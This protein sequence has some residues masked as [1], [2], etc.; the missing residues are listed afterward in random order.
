[1]LS[2][3]LKHRANQYLPPDTKVN[4]LVDDLA[5]GILLANVLEKISEEKVGRI[6]KNPKMDIQKLENLNQCLDFIKAH[7]IPL[8]NVGSSDILKGN[9]KIILGLM[10]TIILRF[11]VSGADGKAGLLLWLQ[12]STKG[13]AGVD[14]KDFTHSWQDGLAFNALIHRYRPDLVNF[15]SLNTADSLGNCENAFGV[16]ETSLNIARLLD[17]EDVVAMPDEKSQVAYL[18]QFFKLFA[19]QAKLES[20]LKA[21]KNAVEVTRRHDDWI[22]QYNSGSETVTTF[23][24]QSKSLYSL[25][26]ACTT[27]E[28]VK[29]KLD[30]FSMYMKSV[31]PDMASK[32]AESDGI[33]TSLNSSKRNNKRPEFAPAISQ[34]SLNSEWDELEALEQ[35]YERTLLDKYLA[36]MVADHLV[37]Q[38]NAKSATVRTW[39]DEKA[40]LFSANNLG[41][42]VPDI[43]ANLEV[44][45]TFENRFT[46]Y[47]GVVQELEAIVGK[48]AS[49]EGH[50]AASGMKQSMEGL[51]AQMDAVKSS[52]AAHKASLENALQQELLLV[53]KLKEYLHGIDQVD[54]LVDQLEERLGEEISGSSVSEIK[55][56]EE[57][58]GVFELK[59]GDISSQLGDMTTLAQVISCKKA[60]APSHCQDQ[61]SRL[62]TLKGAIGDRRTALQQLLHN[63]TRKDEASRSFATLANAFGQFCDSYRE[64]MDSLSGSLS[65]QQTA[66]FQF[67]QEVSGTDK[68]GELDVAHTECVE[69]NV[70]ANPYTSHTI[71]SLRA[72]SEQLSKAIQRSEDAIT[73]QLMAEQ[74]L[75]IPAEQLKEI[76]EVFRVFDQDHD[77]KLRL[78]DLKEACLGA[79]IDLEDDVLESRMNSRSASMTFTMDDFIA[80]FVEELKAGDTPDDIIAAFKII[81]E[82][83]DIS[84]EKLQK[85]FSSYPD[86]SSYLSENLADGDYVGFTQRIFSR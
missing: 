44:Q 40:V 86:L 48:A 25:G 54:F 14:V 67:H 7:N 43:Q 18:S 9:E 76:Q 79:G 13:Y 34:Q 4:D 36:F 32:R 29:E 17:A 30:S 45:N 71:Y 66:L 47:A 6:N 74:S 52:G 62:G 80:F 27:T 58:L 83:D 49:T 55:Q 61:Q 65:S 2:S 8:V 10:W 35:T 59:L 46:L 84:L 70:V 57:S 28:E 1:L 21:I 69:A 63:E 3:Y 5:S 19:G 77:G 31:K 24:S 11:E 23:I 72:L 51:V 85:N 42:S 39:L 12:R 22:S 81:S 15:D 33:I 64:K 82:G 16:A 50:L 56:L 38:F 20:K 73:S 37:A 75:Q 26:D 41:T 68:L 53:E 60:D 78:A